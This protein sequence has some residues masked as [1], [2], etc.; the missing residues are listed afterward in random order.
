MSISSFIMLEAGRTGF[1]AIFH[2]I[3]HQYKS[4]S[5]CFVRTIPW[6]VACANWMNLDCNASGTITQCVPRITYPSCTDS[7]FQR[8]WQTAIG[9]LFTLWGRHFAMQVLTWWR[10]G[11]S[12]HVDLSSSAT[13]L[14]LSAVISGWKQ[15]SGKTNSC[16][17]VSPRLVFHV[18]IKAQEEACRP[19]GNAH[20]Y[21][22]KELCGKQLDL[23]VK[24]N[25]WMDLCG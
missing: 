18:V 1:D 6:W 5:L 12:S 16:H 13:R 11:Q 8:C 21:V 23:D 15:K 17:I 24:S 22:S 19:S 9:E 10:I 14:L 4:I 20:V 7:S 25:L 2:L 3:V